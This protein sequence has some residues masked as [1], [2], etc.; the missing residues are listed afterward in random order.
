MLAVTGGVGGGVGGSPNK[1]KGAMSD[2]DLGE[3]HIR[4]LEIGSSS[5]YAY[6][7]GADAEQGFEEPFDC[8]SQGKPMIVDDC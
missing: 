2:E 8:D 5:A 6:A 1:D 7:D 3:D 4:G